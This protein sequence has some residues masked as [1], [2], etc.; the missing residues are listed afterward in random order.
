[1]SEG[2][3]QSVERFLRTGEGDFN[4]LTLELFAYQYEKNLPYQAFCKAQSVTPEGVS[5][6]QD[7]PAGWCCP[8]C[9]ARKEDFEM[10]QI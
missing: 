6:W 4:T 8:E 7:I 1:M 5:R 2:I 9:G 10:V 3:G